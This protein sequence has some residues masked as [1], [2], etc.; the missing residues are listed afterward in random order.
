MEHLLCREVLCWT[1]EHLDD[2]LAPPGAPCIAS[3]CTE[4]Q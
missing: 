2:L 1:T 3:H 4:Y